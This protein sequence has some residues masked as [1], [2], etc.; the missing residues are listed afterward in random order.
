M[1]FIRKK[2]KK[3]KIILIIDILKIFSVLII[4]NSKINNYSILINIYQVLTPVLSVCSLSQLLMFSIDLKQIKSA[5]SLE[6]P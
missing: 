3:I 6:I 5:V 2:P 4:F 1:S